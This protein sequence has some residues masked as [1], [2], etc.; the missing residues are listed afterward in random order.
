MGLPLE[1]FE[2]YKLSVIGGANP[3]VSGLHASNLTSNHSAGSTSSSTPGSLQSGSANAQ[4]SSLLPSLS[5]SGNP[6][7]SAALLNGLMSAAGAASVGP[8]ALML[9]SSGSRISPLGR[10]AE[11]LMSNED[12]QSLV[13][14]FSVTT[15]K[16]S[17]DARLSYCK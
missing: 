3:G 17:V 11:K 2:A 12:K 6:S 5:P 9:Q 15:R 10:E 1:Q 16:M 8:G 7:V 13:N 4:T 14:N